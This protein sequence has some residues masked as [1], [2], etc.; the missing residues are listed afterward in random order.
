MHGDDAELP[1]ESA[2]PRRGRASCL[3]A[4][5]SGCL[6]MARM[7][8][9][10]SPLRSAT[11]P[12]HA[13]RWSGLLRQ[14]RTVGTLPA[15][16]KSAGT[17]RSG[18]NSRDTKKGEPVAASPLITPMVP[19]AECNGTLPSL[20]LGLPSTVLSPASPKSNRDRAQRNLLLA[21]FRFQ[22]FKKCFRVKCKTI[23][24]PGDFKRC[25]PRRMFCSLQCFEAHW[26]E[27]LSGHLTGPV[28]RDPILPKKR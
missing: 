2:Q 10:R 13:G 9:P 14:K 27:R 19:L 6:S 12:A 22:S 1:A 26:R 21:Q 4:S 20:L 11:K 24:V 3:A 15:N 8:I 23:F 25:S 18:N 5:R 17:I 28:E 16:R 7:T